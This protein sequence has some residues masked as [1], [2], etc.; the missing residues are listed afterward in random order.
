MLENLG[1]PIAMDEDPLEDVIHHLLDFFR[2]LDDFL[3]LSQEHLDSLTGSLGRLLGTLRVVLALRVVQID[4]EV[5]SHVD[6]RS[7]QLHGWESGWAMKTH[8]LFTIDLA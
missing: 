7:H 3:S 2:V 1:S 6:E 8:K 5:E 4:A